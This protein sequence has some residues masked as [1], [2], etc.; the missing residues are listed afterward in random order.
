MLRLHNTMAEKWQ[1]TPRLPKLSK[2]N[3]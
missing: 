2:I 1:N 3:N